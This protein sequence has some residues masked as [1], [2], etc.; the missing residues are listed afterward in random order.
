MVCDYRPLKQEKYRIRL[1]IGG[2]RLMYGDETASLTA[3]LIETKIIINST[4]SNASKGAC[5]MGIDIKDFFLQTPLPQ[6]DT[7]RC[8]YYEMHKGI[9]GLKQAA[10]LAYK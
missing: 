2:D 5:S 1:T 10:I 3:L 8:V 6:V 9:C 4:I 7:D